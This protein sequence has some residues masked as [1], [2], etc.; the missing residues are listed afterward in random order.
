MQQQTQTELTPAEQVAAVP[1]WWHS[2]DLG[3]GLVTPGH[4]SLEVEH[5][6]LDACGVPQDLTGKSVLDIGAYDGFYSFEAEKRGARRVVALDH[7]VWERQMD[8]CIAYWRDCNERGVA[9]TLADTEQYVDRANLP[10]KRPFDTAHRLLNSKVEAVTADFMTMNLDALGQFDY[11]F[12]FGVLYHMEEPLS[13]VRRLA[14][15][16]KETA[17]ISTH[18]V[19]FEGHE[20]ASAWEFYPFSEL[21]ND[22]TNW[23][24]PTEKALVGSC[25]EAG[26]S[27]VEVLTGE[28]KPVKPVRRSALGRARGVV[29]HALREFGLRR[30]LPDKR[31]E[32]VRYQLRARAYK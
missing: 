18:G 20:G 27:R 5:Y 19:Y 24:A 25:L 26:F 2:I 31:P 21:N 6:T 28:P 13:A 3:G 17:F 11:V 30:P 32:A 8:K 22:E 29:G 10:G 12:Y 23:F 4:H 16:T 7:H 14:R 1:F 15:A 9:A